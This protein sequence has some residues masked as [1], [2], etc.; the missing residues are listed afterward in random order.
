MDSADFYLTQEGYQKL[1]QELEYLKNVRRRE[2]AR[3]IEK[4]R[5]F[6]DLS[7]N[8][9]YDAAKDAQAHNEKRVNELSF[10]LSHARIIDHEKMTNDEVLIGAKVSL[11]DLDTGEEL[12]YTLVSEMEADYEQNKISVSSPVGQGLLNH[13]ENEEVDIK[14]PAGVLRYK[15]VKITR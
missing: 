13:K 15:I 6:G 4:A 2:I 9:E 1:M 14:I 11:K 10:K 3:E 8:A 12:V 7:E 5:G